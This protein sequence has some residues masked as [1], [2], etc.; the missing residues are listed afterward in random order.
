VTNLN[1][2]KYKY[3]L[4]QMYLNTLNSISKKFQIFFIFRMYNYVGKRKATHILR[5]LV[6]RHDYCF[7][8][9]MTCRP[10]LGSIVIANYITLKTNSK[11][12][13]LWLL[14]SFNSVFSFV[15][16]CFTRALMLCPLYYSGQS[17]IFSIYRA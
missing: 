17:T 3:V 6:Y 15:I 12:S 8:Y 5:H 2:F 13:S 11:T 4:I 9:M 10:V 1:L 7:A 14:L 16:F